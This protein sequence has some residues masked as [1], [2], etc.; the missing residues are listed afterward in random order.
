[1]EFVRRASLILAL[2]QTARLAASKLMAVLI[3]RERS[4][5]LDKECALAAG[6]CTHVN[7]QQAAAGL[8]ER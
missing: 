3:E 5:P 1:M 4:G 8:F 2:T 7:A 6:R